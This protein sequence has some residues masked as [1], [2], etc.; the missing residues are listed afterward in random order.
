[1]YHPTGW[2]SVKKLM[3]MSAYA[4][5]SIE[6][7][8]ACNCNDSISIIPCRGARDWYTYCGGRRIIDY[9]QAPAVVST[10]CRLNHKIL[11][12]S[13]GRVCHILVIH[14]TV[15]FLY[16]PIASAI[17]SPEFVFSL[18]R[19]PRILFPNGSVTSFFISTMTLQR[20]LSGWSLSPHVACTCVH[21][22]HAPHSR[23][24]HRRI[25]RRTWSTTFKMVMERTR[26]WRNSKWRNSKC[27]EQ[28][29]SL[30]YGN[31]L[32]STMYTI[33][34]YYTVCWDER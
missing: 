8:I 6:E 28:R 22:V 14:N 32:H 17:D 34:L 33:F 23:R 3:R 9:F 25:H 16:V 11:S 7:C 4:F 19:R 26:S 2:K 10:V 18:V 12:D 15:W 13:V 31:Y 29:Y 21:V 24:I 5:P 30:S 1:M 20:Q 27:M